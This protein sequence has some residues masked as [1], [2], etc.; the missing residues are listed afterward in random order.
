[1]LQDVKIQGRLAAEAEQHARDLAERDRFMRRIAAQTGI[2]QLPGTQ[3][4]L[5][6]SHAVQST[7]RQSCLIGCHPV[8]VKSLLSSLGR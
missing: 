3:P 7:G 6:S 2:L 5:K 4:N 1:M 8:T